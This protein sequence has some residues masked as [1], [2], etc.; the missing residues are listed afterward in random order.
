M[1]VLIDVAEILHPP[2]KQACTSEA[3]TSEVRPN[4]STRHPW[5]KPRW[6]PKILRVVSVPAVGGIGGVSGL[7]CRMWLCG[8]AAAVMA[9]PHGGSPG[10]EVEEA[11]RGC[12]CE[13]A[14]HRY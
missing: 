5:S 8:V 3:G 13:L 7:P 11:P 4:G 14:C 2:P 10:I 12:C 1:T 9:I 6:V